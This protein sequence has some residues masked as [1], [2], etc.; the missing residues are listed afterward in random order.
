M[1]NLNIE[2]KARCRGLAIARKTAKKLGASFSV[3]T[4]QVDTYYEVP[5]G[6]LKLRESSEEKSGGLIFY[7]RKNISGPK[8]SNV[9]RIE[10][11]N[12]REL[13]E[14]LDAALNIKIVVDKLREIWWLDNVKIHFDEVRGLGTFIEFEVITAQEADVLKSRARARELMSAFGIREGDLVD[15]SYSDM[16]LK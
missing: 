6:R 11:E 3:K 13:K 16:F 5:R 2:I 10:L 4:Q 12:A 14:V 7:D 8:I 1:K 9:K 15:C